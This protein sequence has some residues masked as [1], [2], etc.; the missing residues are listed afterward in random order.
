RRGPCAGGGRGG[1]VVGGL[2]TTGDGSPASPLSAASRRRRS[3]TA[4]SSTRSVPHRS[5]PGAHDD[6][7]GALAQELLR[8]F[9]DILEHLGDR[10][11]TLHRSGG[12]AHPDGMD[13]GIPLEDRPKRIQRGQLFSTPRTS[14]SRPCHSWVTRLARDR[15]A[16]PVGN[17]MSYMMSQT[18]V[19]TVS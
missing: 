6:G 1:P 5:G 3:P 7:A 12:L 8:A 10:A 15:P 17:L 13:V 2:D 14:D 4:S 19:Y 9:T 11:D 18:S 16:I